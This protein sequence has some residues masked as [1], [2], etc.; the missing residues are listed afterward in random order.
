M[1]EQARAELPNECCGLLAGVLEEGVARLVADERRLSRGG[2]E[3]GLAA[4]LRR[5]REKHALAGGSR[6]RSGGKT[7]VQA[8]RL[9]ERAG[10]P[11]A[12]RAPQTASKRGHCPVI[13]SGSGR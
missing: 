7:V 8:A 3:A 4:S 12:P 5:A 9:P 6:L 10:A 2:M 11:P 13:N 1:I